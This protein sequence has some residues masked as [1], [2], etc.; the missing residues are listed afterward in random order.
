MTQEIYLI[1]HVG[2]N[3]EVYHISNLNNF[4][5]KIDTPV[6][7]MPLPEDT[8]EENILVKMEGNTAKIDVSWTLVEGAHFGHFNGDVFVPNT[9][10]DETVLGQIETFKEFVPK[11]I[12]DSYSI[13]I[14]G[15]NGLI[16][17]GTISSMNFSVSGSSPIVW[18]VSLSFYVGNVV[19][20]LEA[21]IPPAPTSVT[22]VG[23]T[24]NTAPPAVP[25]TNSRITFTLVPYDGYA[26]P[27]TGSSATNGVIIKY[28]KTKHAARTDD[29]EATSADGTLNEWITVPL[30]NAQL[31]NPTSNA[32][33]GYVNNS[34]NGLPHGEY[35]VKIAQTN[36]FSADAGTEYYRKGATTTSTTVVVG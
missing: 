7:P 3:D 10:T 16:D 34:G 11:S 28:K 9:G 33:G 31:T 1:K 26:D 27:P 22:L 13:K 2:S 15:A 8:H 25:G 21:D 14:T 12:G 5:W 6:T 36:G 35:T 17:K 29:S 20:M 32:I 4:T 30:T 18:N 24:G 19:A 23:S